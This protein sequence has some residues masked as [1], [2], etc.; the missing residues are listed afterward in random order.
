MLYLQGDA[1]AF[2]LGHH[3]GLRKKELLKLMNDSSRCR[4][5]SPNR[6][7]VGVS[8][9]CLLSPSFLIHGACHSLPAATWGDCTM[10]S[11]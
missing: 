11:V 8:C 7:Q 9:H 3:L 1:I 5:P 10:F 6:T 4:A 2:V